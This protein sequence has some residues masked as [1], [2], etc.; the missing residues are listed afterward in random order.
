LDGPGG[1]IPV[2][3]VAV[4]MQCTY[5]LL[6]RAG[7]GVFCSVG[8]RRFF[9]PGLRLH[10]RRAQPWLRMAAGH[11]EAVR[12]A[13]L[14]GA[15]TAPTLGRQRVV[16]SVYEG[17]VSVR[18]R[19]GQLRPYVRPVTQHSLLAI[20]GMRVRVRHQS[21]WRARGTRLLT[22]LPDFD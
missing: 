10:R 11:R 7:G 20:M 3:L 14:T 15:S 9:V 17:P 16:R 1:T 6:C 21:V 8:S 5:V 12:G 13:C 4:D 18:E 19:S 22:V 2:S